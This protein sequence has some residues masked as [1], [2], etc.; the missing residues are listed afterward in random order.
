MFIERNNM[1]EIKLARIDSRLLH[2]SLAYDW[3]KVVDFDLVLVANDRF[4]TDKFN[5]K[6]MALTLPRGMEA[7]FLSLDETVT[8][9]KNYDEDVFLLVENSKDLE[10]LLDRGLEITRVNIGIMHCSKGKKLITSDAAM[11][12][13]D[14][15]IF[16]N[17]L[18]QGADIFLQ[19]SPFSVK[20]Q[21]SDFLF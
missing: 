1:G 13:E 16:K 12:K 6:I 7:K 5:Q 9:L 18:S 15:R 2:G 8:F 4:S 3:E 20:R 14:F 19:V 11:D 21:L 10:S 17:L